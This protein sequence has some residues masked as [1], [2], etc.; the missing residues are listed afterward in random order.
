ME[1]RL[2][3]PGLGWQWDGATYDKNEHCIGDE[4]RQIHK[5]MC[6][7]NC[8]CW[9]SWQIYCFVFAEPSLTLTFLHIHIIHI[10][11][12]ILM[13]I[14]IKYCRKISHMMLMLI[15]IKYCRSF[16]RLFYCRS[17]PHIVQNFP[18]TPESPELP[19]PL[20]SNF[21]IHLFYQSHFF[22]Q[23]HNCYQKCIKLFPIKYTNKTAFRE[24][25]QK[26]R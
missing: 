4:L 24:A 18:P 17:L 26:K 22:Y 11:H 23:F 13:L 8:R 14:I 9:W 7:F 12:M 1:Q 2:T 5:C 15:M 19:S 10:A 25:P 20:G 16:N 6:M 3:F 21:H